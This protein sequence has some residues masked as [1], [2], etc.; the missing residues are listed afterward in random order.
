MGESSEQVSVDKNKET[1][2][3]AGRE[4]EEKGYPTGKSAS[5]L[6]YGVAMGLFLTTLILY[7]TTLAP[8]VVTL[9]DDSL[10]FQLVTYQLGIAHPTGY[11][12]YM[13][14]GKLFTFLPFG[15]VA[16]RVNLMSAVFGAATV[17]LLY[18]LVLRAARPRPEVRLDLRQ[19]GWPVH[20]GAIVGAGLLAVGQVFWQQATV[21]E[22]Y[23]L[24]AFFVAL[25]LLLATCSPA[26]IGWLA[27]LLGLSLTHHRTMLL[28]LPALGIYLFLHHGFRLLRPQRLILYAS[29]AGLPLLFYLYLP[30]RGTVGSLDGTYENTLTGFWRQVSA[31]GYGLFIFTNPFG[32]ERDLVFYW[33]L[34]ADQ[35]YTAVPGLIGLV[36]LL[37]LGQRK[38]LALTG[39]AFLTYLTF[40]FFYNVTDIEVFFIPNF[41]IWA[42]W[43]GIGVVFLLHTA[44]TLRF[45]AWRPLNVALF[46][47]IFTFII[48]R[49][50]QTNGA[51]ISRTYTWAV[52][53]YGLDMLA[54]PRSQE[55]SAVVG[56]LGEMTL[57]RYF[58]Q[59][60]NRRPDVET[61]AADREKARLEIVEKLLAQNKTIYLT[62]EL[63][64]AADRWSLSA[65]GPLIRV[66]PEP[67]ITPPEFSFEVGQS[68]IPEINLLGYNLARPPHTGPGPAPVRLTLYWQA[69]APLSANLKVS[70]RLLNQA[71]QVIATIDAAPVHFAYPTSAWRP[72]EIVADVY[73]LN[74]PLDAA[75]GPYTPLLIWYDPAQNAA[76]V[77]RVELAPLIIEP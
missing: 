9:F 59:T 46:L 60:E 58:Q 35:F 37:R 4:A 69:L 23:T 77:G 38:L 62:R 20:V 1:G 54:Q 19:P 66:D 51:I 40:N 13:L 39:L 50:W 72:G 16:Y 55:P 24:N 64:G 8:S 27:F 25:L 14:L 65:V 32:H 67:V 6:S 52:H 21:A 18:L 2:E 49:L 73:D 44:A 70:A 30:L 29:L 41:L 56:I 47:A 17:A 15:N 75:P 36:Y 57:L 10:E 12:L 42:I 48:F 31:G 71:G 5:L 28:L 26:R 33:S 68:P 61:V 45:K 74:L 11:P 76:E 63:P 7:L 22:V 43:S 3:Q 53:D 34:L